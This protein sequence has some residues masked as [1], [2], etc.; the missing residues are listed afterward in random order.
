M[1]QVTLITGARNS[2]KTFCAKTMTLAFENFVWINGRQID[3]VCQPFIFSMVNAETDLIVFDDLILE[4]WPVI[5]SII[6]TDKIKVERR[7]EKSF[8]IPTPKI[9]ATLNFELDPTKK[10]RTDLIEVV[11]CTNQG[12]FEFK[13]SRNVYSK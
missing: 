5:K 7:G 3:L 9:I 13:K 1:K 10:M 11:N 8:T 4:N 6:L 12:F 2:G